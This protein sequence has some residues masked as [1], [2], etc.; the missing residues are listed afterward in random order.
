MSWPQLQSQ[1]PLL[2]EPSEDNHTF[3]KSLGSPLAVSLLPS[4]PKREF[5][6]V[7]YVHVC[8]MAHVLLS[9]H[10]HLNWSVMFN[11][12]NNKSD[13]LELF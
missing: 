1:G 4:P 11:K 6:P 10:L 5:S 9:L 13:V 7:T 2:G 8:T 3:S 12:G